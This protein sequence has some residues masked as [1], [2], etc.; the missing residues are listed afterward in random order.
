MRDGWKGLLAAY[1]KLCMLYSSVSL[2]CTG[3]FNSSVHF[4]SDY[5]ATISNNFVLTIDFGS[6]LENE[7]SIILAVGFSDLRSYFK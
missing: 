2:L 4:F 1:A 3:L 7:L 5:A 6:I